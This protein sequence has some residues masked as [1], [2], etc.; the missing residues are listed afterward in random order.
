MIDFPLHPSSFGEVCHLFLIFDGLAVLV[1]SLLFIL[2]APG[3]KRGDMGIVLGVHLLTPLI[4]PAAA[5][6]W[7]WMRRTSEDGVEVSKNK[8]TA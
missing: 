4:G 2:F 5:L 8:K 3:P 1:S 6:F 7:A